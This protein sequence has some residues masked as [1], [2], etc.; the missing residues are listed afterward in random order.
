LREKGVRANAT[1]G[2]LIL[3]AGH[4]LIDPMH[5]ITSSVHAMEK[6]PQ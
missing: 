1:A 6:A 5:Q 3:S 4:R 2:W